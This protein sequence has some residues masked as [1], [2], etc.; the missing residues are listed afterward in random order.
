MKLV[1]RVRAWWSG[2]EKEPVLIQI[3]DRYKGGK[4]AEEVESFVP[5]S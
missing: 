4:R 1:R 2:G 5:M 3:K